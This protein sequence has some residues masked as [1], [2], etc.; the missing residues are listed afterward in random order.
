MIANNILSELQHL[1]RADKLRVMQF[2]LVELAKDEG[3]VLKP[4]AE[5]PIWSPFNSYQ[6]AS[7]LMDLLNKDKAAGAAHV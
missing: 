6:A 3:A 4:N 2:L 7:V 5:Y 1:D